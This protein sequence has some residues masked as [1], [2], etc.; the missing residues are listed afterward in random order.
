V[1]VLGHA[2]GGKRRKNNGDQSE[3]GREKEGEL[4]P[5][6]AYVRLIFDIRV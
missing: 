4:N 6:A 1:H 5:G 2:E 3:G